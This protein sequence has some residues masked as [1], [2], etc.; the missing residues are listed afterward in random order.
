MSVKQH[1]A[2]SSSHSV[3][4]I[5]IMIIIVSRYIYNIRYFTSIKSA[6]ENNLTNLLYIEERI[7]FVLNENAAFQLL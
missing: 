5:V 2:C 1:S 3:S 6:L 7:S 4:Y